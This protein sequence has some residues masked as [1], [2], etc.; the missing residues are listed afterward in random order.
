MSYCI[1]RPDVRIMLENPPKGKLVKNPL[2][3]VAD[4]LGL[5]FGPIVTEQLILMEFSN[6]S[7]TIRIQG[8][9]PKADAD[10]NKV[11]RATDDRTFTYLNSRPVQLP[12]F[13]KHFKSAF[14]DYF[15]VI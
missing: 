7:E 12:N 11:C 6:E 14:R 5:L 4:V 10:Y 1:I 3:S 13:V 9:L 15:G 2:T 8:Y